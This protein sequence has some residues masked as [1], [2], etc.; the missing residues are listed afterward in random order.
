MGSRLGKLIARVAIG[1]CIVAAV[2]AGRSAP[3]WATEFLLR[4]GDITIPEGVVLRGDAIALGG[5]LDVEGTVSGNAMAVG[6][7]VIVGGRVRGSVRAVGG[8]VTLR[9]TAV[10]GGR[11]VAWGGRV[12][13][14]PGATLGGGEWRPGL[15][16]PGVWWWAWPHGLVVFLGVVRWLALLTLLGGFIVGAWVVAVLFPG[17]LARL[18][19]VLE[20]APAGTF[21]L[22]LLGWMLLGPLA[23]VLVLSVIG[24]GLVVLLPVALAIALLFGAGAVAVSVGRRLHEASL[25]KEALVGSV[26]LAVAFAIPHLGWVVAFAVTTWGLGTVLLAV[27][28]HVRRIPP[29]PSGAPTPPVRPS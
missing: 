23:A 15:F 11:A 13:V 27:V 29:P 25:P 16:F 19:G 8:D 4:V 28:E 18:A 26:V 21:G 1:A 17:V 22:G 7:D 3:A 20:R 10:V 24:A 14:E 12:R 9:S 2:V 5:T 6:G